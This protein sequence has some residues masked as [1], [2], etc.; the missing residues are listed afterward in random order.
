V[1]ELPTKPVLYFDGDCGFCS[2]V[3]RKTQRLRLD[4]QIET[5]QS[6]DLVSLGIDPAIAERMIPLLSPNGDV[7][8]G[9]KAIAKAL[10]T[11]PWYW[12]QVGHL[13][14]S[15]ILKKPAATTYAFLARHRHRLPG[16]TPACR[17]DPP[18]TQRTSN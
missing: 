13:L 3:A 12:V 18:D 17:L 11:G 5:L 1:S 2:S 10:E 8:Y 16:G 14:E 4:I 6:V 7:T 15:S 9:H